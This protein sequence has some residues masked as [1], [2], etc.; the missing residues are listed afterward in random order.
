MQYVFLVLQVGWVISAG[1]CTVLQVVILTSAAGRKVEFAWYC[2]WS[3]ISVSICTVL[4]I[5]VS[6]CTVLQ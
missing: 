1:F 6:V 2:R 5:T 3:D 4:L